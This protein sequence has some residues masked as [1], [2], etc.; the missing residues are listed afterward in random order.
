M[1]RVRLILVVTMA[2]LLAPSLA[3]C[4]LAAP[5]GHATMPCCHASSGGGPAM[6]PCCAAG[7]EP[8]AAPPQS[9]S[10]LPQV[11]DL[12]AVAIALRPLARVVACA[13]PPAGAQPRLRS[14]VLLI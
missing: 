4:L 7:D 14:T 8:A 12:P 5:S 13:A 1:V 6:W 10:L 11:I 2:A 3:P 9:V